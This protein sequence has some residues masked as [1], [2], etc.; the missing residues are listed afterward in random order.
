MSRHTVSAKFNLSILLLAFGGV[1]AHAQTNLPIYTDALTN[2]FQDW[3]WGA[4]NFANSAPVHSGSYSINFNG[5]N[6]Q[7]IS[8][9]H[10]D[11]NPAPYTNLSFWINGG[12]NG[13]QVVQ[14]YEIGRASCRER[15]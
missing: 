5:T 4:H 15:V 10:P 3:S 6:W 14:I 7:A 11:F 2:N 12:T 9:W 13:G 1:M 8:C